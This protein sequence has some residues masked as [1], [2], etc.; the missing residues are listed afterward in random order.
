MKPVKKIMGESGKP[1]MMAVPPSIY[2]EV[3]AKIKGVFQG[4]NLPV[5]RSVHDAAETLSKL[6]QYK[7][8]RNREYECDC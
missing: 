2:P 4:R 5:F 8:G 3:E 1:I 6:Y 7:L